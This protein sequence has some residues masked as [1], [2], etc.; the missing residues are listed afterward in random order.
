MSGLRCAVNCKVMACFLGGPIMQLCPLQFKVSLPSGVCAT[1]S[2]AVV[3]R[4]GPFTI[5]S[6]CRRCTNSAWLGH[7]AA[8]HKHW[9]A[10]P[11]HAFCR[12]TGQHAGASP[13]RLCIRRG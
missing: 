5:R 6:S 11:G 1:F 9:G 3:S 13:G 12:V 10:Q 2:L 4:S 8:G 7:H